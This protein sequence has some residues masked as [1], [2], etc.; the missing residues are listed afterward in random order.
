MKK[1]INI[2][3]MTG[4][5]WGS[6]G[7]DFLKLTFQGCS[8]TKKIQKWLKPSLLWPLRQLSPGSTSKIPKRMKLQRTNFFR[9][10]K[11]IDDCHKILFSPSIKISKFAVFS[12]GI[13]V[14]RSNAHLWIRLSPHRNYSDGL[15]GVLLPRKKMSV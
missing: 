2:R 3:F 10:N 13:N 4:L 8:A 1:T 14:F 9:Q 5:L 7:L 15:A 11:Q 6:L 12:T